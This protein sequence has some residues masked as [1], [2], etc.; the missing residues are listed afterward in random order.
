MPKHLKVQMYFVNEYLGKGEA[1][2]TKVLWFDETK[3]KVFG[4]NSKKHVQHIRGQSY[5]MKALFHLSSM[6]EGTLNFGSIFQSKLQYNSLGPMEF[7]SFQHDN[8]SQ[9]RQQK[10]LRN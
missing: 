7:M 10:S 9:S 4:Y 5:N 8:V 1:F 6:V 2:C 3:L